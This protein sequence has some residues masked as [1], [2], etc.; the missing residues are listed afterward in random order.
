MAAAA[1][2]GQIGR[3]GD[4]GTGEAS[5][6]GKGAKKKVAYRCRY[7]DAKKEAIAR[8][9]DDIDAIWKWVGQMNMIRHLELDAVLRSPYDTETLYLKYGRLAGY[10]VDE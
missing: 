9:D 2:H 10:F 1:F 5:S 4:E 8:V 3:A 7:Q 6:G